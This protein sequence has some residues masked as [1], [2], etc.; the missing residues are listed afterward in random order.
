ME[1]GEKQKKKFMY[2]D[3]ANFFLLHGLCY[4]HP[5]APQASAECI[6]LMTV[7]SDV[8]GGSTVAE[9]KISLALA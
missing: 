1:D 4:R 6:V 3:L 5:T 9:N 8:C 7:A 2:L